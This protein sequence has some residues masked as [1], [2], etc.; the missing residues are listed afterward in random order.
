[1]S[2]ALFTADNVRPL[3]W[4]SFTLHGFNMLNNN[5]GTQGQ[6]L[7]LVSVLA[8]PF[9]PYLMILDSEISR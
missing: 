6:S 3:R 2:I 7:W 5:F 4:N 8:V 1:M 9:I